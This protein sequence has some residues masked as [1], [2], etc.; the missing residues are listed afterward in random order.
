[1]Q[2][3]LRRFAESFGKSLVE[4][5]RDIENQNLRRK[6]ETVLDKAGADQGVRDRL[7]GRVKELEAGLQQT[8]PVFTTKLAATGLNLQQEINNLALGQGD[9]DNF[10]A[11]NDVK[12]LVQTAT[13]YVDAGGQTK[14]E[15]ELGTYMRTSAV[16]GGTKFGFAKR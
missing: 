1:M 12:S 13:Q 9:P 14:V 16:A 15:E 11:D 6:V 5:R 3:N 8:T 4:L 7:L 2:G 10:L